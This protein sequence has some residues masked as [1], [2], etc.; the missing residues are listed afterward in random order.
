[1]LNFVSIFGSVA[2]VDVLAS[3]F[4]LQTFKGSG[5]EM[6]N[7]NIATNN[8]LQYNYMME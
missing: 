5:Y 6:L 7:I 2:K 3:L 4:C 8:Y 1:M